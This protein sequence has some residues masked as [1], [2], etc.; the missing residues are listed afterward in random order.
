MS[1]SSG[2]KSRKSAVKRRGRI[3]KRGCLFLIFVIVFMLAGAGGALWYFKP[4]LFGKVKGEVTRRVGEAA[5]ALPSIKEGKRDS[6]TLYFADPKWTK[7]VAVKR[8]VASHGDP[9]VRV[10]KII[11]LLTREGGAGTAPPLPSSAKLK[12]AYFGKD[13]VIVVDMEP[14][15][16]EIS[17]WGVSGELLAVY[18]IVNSVVENVEGATKVR[19]LVDGKP[20]ETLAGHVLIEEPLS[21]RRDI[22]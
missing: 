6:V 17:S 3:N 21:P 8:P 7:L 20:K 13:G 19:I 22:F 12:N 5:S 16:D 11:E 15:L 9:A 2:G 10:R 14:S 1:D 4:D 18:S